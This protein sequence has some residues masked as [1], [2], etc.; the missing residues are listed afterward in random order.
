[1]LSVGSHCS[2]CVLW[3]RVMPVA[4]ACERCG[5]SF[6]RMPSTRSAPSSGAVVDANTSSSLTL[7]S[8]YRV[9]LRILFTPTVFTKFSLLFTGRLCMQRTCINV[10]ERGLEPLKA[11][12]VTPAE[13][14]FV[15]LSSPLS[16]R[17]NARGGIQLKSSLRKSLKFSSAAVRP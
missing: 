15:R 8:R 14:A 11:D 4:K 5:K 3:S 9:F 7:F 17:A 2:D 10:V 13:D 1:M 12:D 16:V 6:P